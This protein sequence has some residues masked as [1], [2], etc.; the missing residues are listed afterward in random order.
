MGGKGQLN[1][2]MSFSFQL[3]ESFKQSL[4]SNKSNQ[5]RYR[6]TNPPTSELNSLLQLFS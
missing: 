4:K 1:D 6:E 2:Q 5:W 3:G